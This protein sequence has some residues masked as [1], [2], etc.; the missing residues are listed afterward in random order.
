MSE[1][2][3]YG[4]PP[5]IEVAIGVQ[6]SPIA[7]FTAAHLGL[8]WATVRDTFGRVEEQPPI[9]HVIEPDPGQPEP[10]PSFQIS[11]KPELPRV[12]LI[13]GTGNRIIQVQRDRFL[14][15]WRKLDP[16]DE[17]PRFPSVK[18]SFLDHWTS[19]QEFLGQAGLN[20]EP[21]QCELTYV[22]HLRKGEGWN[23]L[24]D[25][26]A[27]FTTFSWHTRERFL[28]APDNLRWSL[29][30]LLPEGRGRLHVDVVPVRA[31][32]SNDL[33]V[34]FALTARGKPSDI[35]D[36]TSMSEWY[37]LAREWIVRGFAD[38]VED[39]TDELWEK[40]T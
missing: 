33:A 17:Y 15:N 26:G 35:D 4:N 27:L 16:E 10:G 32:P 5:L 20:P 11:A 31:Q 13:D 19:F 8:Y 24:A 40:K 36:T 12:W 18:A 28:P 23:T 25:L 29:R 34:R 21:D 3:E 37:D 6:F 7:E 2:P 22:N 39:K 9:S 30:F 14:H 1:L 38:L